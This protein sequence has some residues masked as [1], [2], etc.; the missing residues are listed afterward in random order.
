MEITET[1]FTISERKSNQ[2]KFDK[3][4]I[5]HVLCLI[6]QGVPRRDIMN[7]YGMSTGALIRCMQGQNVATVLYWFYFTR[8]FG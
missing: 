3:R 4:L 7:E 2:Q 6:E 5:R 8:L 1:E